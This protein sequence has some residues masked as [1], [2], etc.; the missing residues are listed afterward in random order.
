M[1]TNPETMCLFN[2]ITKQNIL[3]D[4]TNPAMMYMFNIIAKQNTLIENLK[5]DLK[6]QKSIV[7]KQ[8][9]AIVELDDE[10]DEKRHQLIKYEVSGSQ[11]SPFEKY[12]DPIESDEEEKDLPDE[13]ED[14]IEDDDER[15]S[16][17]M[18]M[19]PPMGTTIT[20]ILARDPLPSH[21]AYFK[22]KYDSFVEDIEKMKQVAKKKIEEK[23]REQ[24]R[25]LQQAIDHKKKEEL[26]MK[27]RKRAETDLKWDRFVV[28]KRK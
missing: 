1:T 23:E 21:A 7:V 22:E 5:N 8:C 12:D 26:R 17:I 11:A 10:L 4:T 13:E 28:K 27:K 19:T 9:E 15:V 16:R 3:I 25:V 24:R 20:E 2:T 6:D 18:D 14:E